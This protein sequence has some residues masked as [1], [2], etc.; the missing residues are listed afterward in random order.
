MYRIEHGTPNREDYIRI[1]KETGLSEKSKE[2]A[3]A[4]LKNTIFAVSVYEK[5]ILVAMGRVIGDGC[6]FLKIVDIAVQQAL[7]GQGIGK[8]VMNELVTYLHTNAPK[9]AYISLIADNPTNKLYEKFGFQYVYPDSH[10]M[11]IKIE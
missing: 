7:Q 2:V 6:C 4:G 5:D 8:K 3:E 9:S 1:R 10:G 11:Y